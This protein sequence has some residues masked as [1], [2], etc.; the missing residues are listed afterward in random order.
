AKNRGAGGAFLLANGRGAH[1][2]PALALSREPYLAVAEVA[3]TAAQGRVLLA[4]A[5]KLDEIE[6]QFGDRIENRDEITFD[7]RSES[8]RGRKLRRL[9]A[10]A[11]AERP[12]K[13]EPSDESARLL[14]EGVARLG[15]ARLPWTKA[16][17][18]W[19]DRVMFLRK[20]EGD[21]WP[22]LS[23][24]ALAANV[25]WLVPIVAGITALADLGA[26]AFSDA[27]RELIPWNLRR[28]LD[29]EA[30]THFVAPSGSSV[31]I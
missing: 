31:P 3:G 15:I 9:G 11:L 18:H 24:P 12:M 13:I 20:A 8:L 29:A 16:L 26:D 21:E 1:L 17:R 14:A 28:R 6:A 10:L 19:R 23:D 5:I 27:A 7:D 30:P 4:A 22:D 25:D 2:D